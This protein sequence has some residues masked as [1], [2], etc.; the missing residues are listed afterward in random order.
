MRGYNRKGKGLYVCKGCD[1]VVN[2]DINGALNIIRK[3]AGE[4][5]VER[6]KV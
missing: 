4:F 5:A 6:I 3:V 2:A 1:S